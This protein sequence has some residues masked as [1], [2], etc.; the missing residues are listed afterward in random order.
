VTPDAHAHV[1][2]PPCR[3]P[4]PLMCS[5]LRDRGR[6]GARGILGVVVRPGTFAPVSR[7]TV[8][9][10]RAMGALRVRRLFRGGNPA[11]TCRGNEVPSPL[12]DPAG[13]MPF[14]GRGRRVDDP[15]TLGAH[16]DAT[17]P[18]LGSAVSVIARP[19]VRVSA[20]E[21]LLPTPVGARRFVT[22]ATH[23][24]GVG[25]RSSR[26]LAT[27]SRE[28]RSLYGNEPTRRW[29][30]DIT[31]EGV[32]RQCI[33]WFNPSIAHQSSCRSEPAYQARDRPNG[34]DMGY[35]VGALATTA[36]SR[37]PPA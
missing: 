34:P 28:A 7:Q 33:H 12:L 24:R 5:L 26:S 23:E 13:R 16:L 3:A 4:S 27:T 32:P 19:I 17:W 6:L 11:D 29:T 8:P 31:R 21:A 14:R 25:V 2:P 18:S 15:A 30:E 20:W 1:P 10:V 9:L 22:R 35:T 36:P 37:Y